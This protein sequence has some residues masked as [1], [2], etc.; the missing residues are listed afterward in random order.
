MTVVI[1]GG[2][3]VTFPDTVQQTNAVTNTGGDPRY[4]AAR[5]WV[6]FNGTGTPSVRA[7]VNVASITD[8]GTGAYTVTFT[9]PM[10]DANYAVVATTIDSDSSGAYIVARVYGTPSTTSFNIMVSKQSS[11]NPTAF[12]P[13]LVSVVVF[14]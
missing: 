3:G 1:D 9:T 14:R 11:G 13:D 12:D 6:R 8:N 4:Y 2:A 5:A 10:P 7:G